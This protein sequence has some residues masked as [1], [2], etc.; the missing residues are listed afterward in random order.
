MKPQKF[1]LFMLVLICSLINISGNNAPIGIAE[2]SND[3]KRTLEDQIDNY[4][5]LQ[6][7]KEVSYEVVIPNDFCFKNVKEKSLNNY[8]LY[9]QQ[10]LLLV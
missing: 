9:L 7:N 3:S 10:E 1:V 4:I 8:T 6:F 5:I 2:S